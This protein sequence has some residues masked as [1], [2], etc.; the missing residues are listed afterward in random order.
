MGTKFEIF[1][2]VINR[3]DLTKSG[4][5]ATFKVYGQYKDDLGTRR[6]LVNQF[7][8][9]R[10]KRA[11]DYSISEIKR[12]VGSPFVFVPVRGGSKSQQVSFH[13][14][15]LIEC[16]SSMSTTQFETKIDHKFRNHI[17]KLFKSSAIVTD[18]WVSELS[19]TMLRK[20]LRYTVRKEEDQISDVVDGSTFGDDKILT[21]MKSFYFEKWT[22][23]SLGH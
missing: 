9:P 17:S 22:S 16:P 3:F 12:E 19:K 18:V 5:V 14:H 2:E 10:F 15:A 1:N 8:I 6:N 11:V 7:S 21:D 13:I 4:L 23:N 20:Y